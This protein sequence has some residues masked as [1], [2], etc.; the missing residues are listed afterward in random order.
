MKYE[1]DRH[2]D[3]GGPDASTTHNIYIDLSGN[4]GITYTTS[5]VTVNSV[6]YT[7]GIASVDDMT[8]NIVRT[9]TNC[10]SVHGFIKGDGHWL[11]FQ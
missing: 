10:N 6:K 1:Y 3:V 2:A 7:M 4:P 8:I 9:Y 11:Y 5:L